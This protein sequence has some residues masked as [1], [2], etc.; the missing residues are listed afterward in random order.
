MRSYEGKTRLAHRIAYCEHHGL[1][2]S[3]ID[4][5]VVRHRCDNPP[6]VNPEHLELG[7]QAD[8]MADCAKRSRLCSVLTAEQV[9]FIRNHYK[10]R[11]PEYGGKALARRFGVS[12]TT[13]SMAFNRKVWKHT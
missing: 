5:Y 2:L 13:I 8:N 1:H 4:G 12:Q 10:P 9:A 7:T 11:C 6:C 3:A